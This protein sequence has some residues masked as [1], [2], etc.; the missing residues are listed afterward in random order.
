MISWCGRVRCSFGLDE[1]MRPA[2]P[3]EAACFPKRVRSPFEAFFSDRLFTL[4][5]CSSSQLR[6]GS[7]H[8]AGDL[9]VR[10][11]ARVR[12]SERTLFLRDARNTRSMSCKR[13]HVLGAA[14]RAALRGHAPGRSA[15]VCERQIKGQK[16]SKKVA[17]EWA[18]E[19][20]G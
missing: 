4:S 2:R 13:P 6:S 7:R 16:N 18:R 5:L 9:C 17:T 3:G 8:E 11:R 10:A 20:A 12:A 14:H 15:H 19:G 1:H